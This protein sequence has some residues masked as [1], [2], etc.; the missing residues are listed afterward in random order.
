MESQQTG[1]MNRTLSTTL[2]KCKPGLLVFFMFHVFIFPSKGTGRFQTSISDACWHLLFILIRPVCVPR[3]KL[4][5]WQRLFLSGV[6]P[7][8]AVL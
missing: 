7:V 1:T 8:Y 6:R 4:C 2:R 5:V 3:L